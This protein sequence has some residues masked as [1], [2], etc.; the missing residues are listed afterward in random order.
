M[1]TPRPLIDA[2]PYAVFLRV[3]AEQYSVSALAALAGLDRHTV[4]D[5]ID[6]T[7]PRIQRRTAERI[8]RLTALCPSE[9]AAA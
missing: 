8:H 1:R 2:E 5:L 3:M 9:E 6:G 4:A 7:K